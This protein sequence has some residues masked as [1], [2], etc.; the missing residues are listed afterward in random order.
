[1]H[2]AITANDTAPCALC[3]APSPC[4]DCGAPL[5]MPPVALVAELDAAEL[6]DD[7][8]GALYLAGIR[9]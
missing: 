4:A 3:G 2:D 6:Y 8:E 9:A 5:T 1:M 7:D